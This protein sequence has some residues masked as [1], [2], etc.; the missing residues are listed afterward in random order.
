MM[1]QILCKISRVLW[2]NLPPDRG[3]EVVVPNDAEV[4]H[5]AGSV[6]AMTSLTEQDFTAL[7]PPFEYEYAACRHAHTSDGPP[8]SSRRYPTYNTCPLPTMSDKLLGQ[9]KRPLS[10]HLLGSAEA[11]RVGVVRATSAGKAQEKNMAAWAGDSGPAGSG[12]SQQ[13]RFPGVVLARVTRVH[14]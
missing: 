8:R 7:R 1:H 2:P 13:R 6:R 14:P 4:I 10:T 12:L 3:T 5:R 9:P 11:W